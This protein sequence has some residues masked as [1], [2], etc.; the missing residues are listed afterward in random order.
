MAKG[1][2]F[3]GMARGKVGDVVF[4]RLNGE[5]ISRVR[6]RH[7]KN[8]RTNAQLYQR[9]V[10]ATIMQAY[11]AGKAIFDHSFQGMRVGDENMRRFLS[12]NIKSLRG[13]LSTEVYNRVPLEDEQAHF[14]APG[15]VSPVPVV[16]LIASEG[17]LSQNFLAI[18]DTTNGTNVTVELVN[19]PQGTTTVEQYVTDNMLKA[20]DIYTIIV[21]VTNKNDVRFMLDTVASDYATQYDAKFGWLRLVVKEDL[22]EGTMEGK[23]LAD[24]FNISADGETLKPNV[25]SVVM[26]NGT[27]PASTLLGSTPAIGTIGI[28]RSRDDEDVRSTC[29]MQAMNENNAYGL[30]SWYVLEAWQKGEQALGNS[31]LILEGGNEGLPAGSNSENSNGGGSSSGG[32]SVPPGGGGD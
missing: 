32:P 17:S 29:I 15:S 9:A 18:T 28:I 24:L 1:N 7:P 5:Q 25:G 8:P 10:M 27:I 16:G 2:L 6:N 26:T 19:K 21:F 14:V 4:S 12:R 22:P 20:G 30:V 31:D 23:T 3:Q 11:S 13:Q